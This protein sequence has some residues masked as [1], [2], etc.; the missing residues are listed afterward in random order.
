VWPF[1]LSLFKRRRPIVVAGR[2][3]AELWSGGS[4]GFRCAGVAPISFEGPRQL[5]SLASA[6]QRMFESAQAESGRGAVHVVLESA[7]LPVIALD[8]GGTPWGERKLQALLA[9]RLGMLYGAEPAARD[10]DLQ[11]DHRAG[12]AVAMGFGLARE[13]KDAVLTAGKAV[14]IATASIQ[15][16]FAWGMGHCLP[17]AGHAQAGWWLWG[18]QDRTLVAQVQRGRVAALNPAAA[19]VCDAESCRALAR[20]EALRLGSDQA[21][22]PVWMGGLHAPTSKADAKAVAVSFFGLQRAVAGGDSPTLEA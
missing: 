17:K 18:E 14:G 3:C 6:L 4:A 1:D 21:G 8:V 22:A 2:S 19:P 11:V 10:W 20:R 9:H 7:W 5:P 13:V 15:P 16:A 12:D